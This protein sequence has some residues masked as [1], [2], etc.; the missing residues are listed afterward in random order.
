M[1]ASAKP[2]RVLFELDLLRALVTVADCGSFTA[3]ALRLHSTQSTVSQRIRR[4]EE[5]AGYVLLTRGKGDVR[6]TDAGET[7]LAYARRQLTLNDALLDALTGAA[8]A[9]TIR[10][11]VPEDFA[12]GRTTELLA[13]FSRRHPHV[14]LE[15]S[16][17]LSRDLLDAYDRGDLD[18]ALV[19]LRRDSRESVARWPEP[20]RWIDSAKSP[21]F[22]LDP[23][24]LVAFPPRGLYRDDMIGAIERMGRRW[25]IS[26]SS[27][28]LSGVQAAVAAGLG[29][30]LLPARAV[31]AGHIV[32]H[33]RQG[34]P[35]IDTM[36][37]ALLHGATADPMVQEL[38]RELG[39]MIGRENK[40]GPARP[41]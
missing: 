37:I 18:M 28:S 13:T 16:A 41:R 14:K 30:S 33:R 15:V 27:T 11:G 36:D 35:A 9:L 7:V 22:Q 1:A 38:G 23:L 29:I 4:L 19:K 40:R 12:A 25:R 8:V 24:P 17:G 3:A 2:N 34:L 5:A 20:M 6:P 39:R 32:L 10:L 21:A 31:T 26:F